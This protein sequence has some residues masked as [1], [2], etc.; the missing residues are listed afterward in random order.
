[1]ADIG[2]LRDL[3]LAAWPETL[4]ASDLELRRR[5]ELVP[6]GQAVLESDGRLVAALY[7]QRIKS[8]DQL[9][10]ANYAALPELHDPA[11]R[12]AQLL[13]IW[14]LEVARRGFADDLLDFML[15]YFATCEGIENLVGV[16]R[17]HHYGHQRELGTSHEDYI[18]LRNEH[19]RLNEPMLQFH[20]AHG[21]VIRAVLP[22]FRP[23]DVQNAGAGVLI[24]YQ[25]RGYS[26][27][28]GNG[29]RRQGVV[30]EDISA[31]VRESIHQV[32]GSVRIHPHQLEAPL[33]EMGS[34]LCSC[35][36]LDICCKNEPPK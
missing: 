34:S 25:L 23:E 32:L 21:A 36:N 12:V 5:V 18:R 17:C 11:G 3:E 8:V 31:V 22:L 24:E 29:P 30:P 7:S 28:L 14:S 13:G 26:P 10:Q 2:Q 9:F 1:M 6:K 33:M 15:G 20:E 27:L 19:G 35:S 4:S 16:T